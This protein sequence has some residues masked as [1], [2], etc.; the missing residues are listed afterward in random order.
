MIHLAE[1]DTRR[2]RLGMRHAKSK[3]NE[4]NR[5]ISDPENGCSPKYGLS[6]EGPQQARKSALGLLP[7]TRDLVICRSNYSRHKQ[8]AAV[9]AE[10]LGPYV[11]CTIITMEGLRERHF[12]KLNE[13]SDENYK[14]V[15]EMDKE[16]PGHKEWGVESV[17]EVADRMTVVRNKIEEWYENEDVIVISS[18]E[19]SRGLL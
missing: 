18:A 13:T 3:A 6:Q 15:W 1:R 10:T 19:H 8:T 5:I 12:G 16:D 2:K 9:V 14:K 17:I 4:L 11:T 7:L